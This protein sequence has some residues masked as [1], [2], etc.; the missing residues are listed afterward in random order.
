MHAALD[1]LAWIAF[2]DARIDEARALFKEALQYAHEIANAGS[3]RES[4]YGLATV[5]GRIGEGRLAAQLAAA[6]EPDVTALSAPT[7]GRG[8]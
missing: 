7:P 2:A 1:N 5:A 6:A 8:R 4:L 3:T